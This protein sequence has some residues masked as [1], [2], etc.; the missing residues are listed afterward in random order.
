MQ[1][2]RQLRHMGV[3]VVC[4]KLA[5]QFH[6]GSQWVRLILTNLIN[7]RIEQRDES[8]ILSFVMWNG[9]PGRNNGPCVF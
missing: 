8:L 7:E 4:N 6:Q 3:F 5:Y 2:S 9:Q 1:T